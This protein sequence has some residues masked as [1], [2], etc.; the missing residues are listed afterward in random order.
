M[1]IKFSGNNRSVIDIKGILIVLGAMLVA[2]I[3]FLVVQLTLASPAAPNPGHTWAEIEK[4]ADCTS[5]QYV[6]G[7]NGSTLD[8]SIPPKGTLS[9]VNKETGWANT[10]P[11]VSISCD[12]GYTM[13]GYFCAISGNVFICYPTPQSNGV[14]C[15]FSAGLGFCKA[16]VRCCKIE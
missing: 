13:T 8:C 12:T 6:Y 7:I 14:Q 9:C 2:G 11:P 4:P 10:N 1:K 5:G 15:H 16:H 3:A